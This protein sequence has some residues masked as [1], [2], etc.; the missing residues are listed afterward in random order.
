M[1]NLQVGVA[2]NGT[3]TVGAGAS[4]HSPASNTLTLG[5]NG[6]E[7]VRIDS[8]GRL[9]LGTTTPGAT[10]C[11]TFTLETSG[12]TGVTLFSGTSNRGTI[13]FGDGRSGNAQYRGVIMY[14][15]SDD[16]M[17]FNTADAERLRIDASGD[18]GLGESAP[19]KSGYGSPVVSIGYNTSNNYSVLELLGNKTSDASI[20]TIVGYNVGGSSRVAAINFL[21]S[22]ANNSGAITFETYASGSAAERMRITSA[23][24][25]NIGGAAVSQSRSLNIGSNAEANLAIETHNDATSETANIRFYKSGNTG[26]SPQVVE[27][28]D[29]IAQL[30]AYGYDGTDYACSAAAIKFSVDGAPGSNDMPGKIILAT[31]ADGAS[32]PTERIRLTCEGRLLVGA[33]AP[34][35]FSGD[36]VDHRFDQKTNDAYT[37]NI[38]A[39]NTAKRGLSI[40]YPAGGTADPAIGFRVDSSWKFILRGDGDCENANNSYGSISDIALKENIVD[41]NSQWNDIKNIKIRNYNFKASTGQQTHT[42]IGVIAQELETVSPKLVKVSEDDMKTVS[43]SVL[44]LKAVKALQEAMAKIEV[45]E[46]KVAALESA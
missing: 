12:H 3:V 29:N 28:D 44:Y 22:G 11:D 2:G 32:S 43:Y 19:N 24:L 38:T 14:D 31:T 21:R 41:A 13:A 10:Q 33:T 40:Y 9:L 46:T 4:V 17:R 30:Q 26:A 18:I 36:P 39:A 15:H 23:G 1:A 27:T 37:V 34:G 6:D 35:T 45:L 8:S 42:Q 25:V 5:T 7:R 16:S 20:S